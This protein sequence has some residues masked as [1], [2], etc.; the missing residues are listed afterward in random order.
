MDAD[1][2]SEDLQSPTPRPQAPAA[3][4]RVATGRNGGASATSV[5][6]HYRDVFA[7]MYDDEPG[8]APV[9]HEGEDEY[10]RPLPMP[11]PSETAIPPGPRA[12]PRRHRPAR[13]TPF[14]ADA[15][16]ASLEDRLAAVAAFG[17]H[18]TSVATG[19]G[20][21]PPPSYP[22]MGEVSR[23]LEHK[24]LMAARARFDGEDI[25]HPGSEV[26]YMCQYGHKGI[27]GRAGLGLQLHGEM[28]RI[29]GEQLTTSGAFQATLIAGDFFD[30]VI[31][32]FFED[33]GVPPPVFDRA[34][35]FAHLD[36]PQHTKNNI[37]FI[38]WAL[39]RLRTQAEKLFSESHEEGPKGMNVGKS[40]EGRMTLLTMLQFYKERPEQLT[41]G[42]PAPGDIQP[43]MVSYLS[44]TQLLGRQLPQMAPATLGWIGDYMKR[45]EPSLS[46]T[47]TPSHA[48]M[49]AEI[50]EQLDGF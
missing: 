47:A 11:P 30:R 4:R 39:D 46:A 48:N 49:S 16:N 36:M 33:L 2:L 9:G 28:L 5:T 32:P 23:S 38:N 27:D 34:A 42:A 45:H 10:G 25:E 21:A 22:T 26:C 14:P 44:R 8:F 40:R 24:M 35:L 18:R 19:A 6:A 20:D 43:E 41:F 1:E 12:R 37:I 15:S 29:I 13:A 31:K 3:P 7:D 17:A 50:A